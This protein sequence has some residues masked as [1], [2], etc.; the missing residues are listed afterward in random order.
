[1]LAECSGCG[2]PLFDNLEY[3]PQCKHKNPDSKVT[4][5][6]FVRCGLRPGNIAP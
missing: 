5:Y 3:C 2:Q 6:S 1:M 4:S